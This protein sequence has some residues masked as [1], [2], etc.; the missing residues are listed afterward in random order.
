MV[1]GMKAPE[2]LDLE[3]SSEMTKVHGVLGFYGKMTATS[4]LETEIWSIY[5]GLTIIMEKGQM[6]THIESDSQTAVTL[7]NEEVNTNHPQSNILNDGKY[8]INRT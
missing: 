8:L 3:A 5:R 4:C 7:F 6:N 1:V 2:E